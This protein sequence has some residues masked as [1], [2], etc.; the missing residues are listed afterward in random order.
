MRNRASRYPFAAIAFLVG[1]LG[2]AITLILGRGGSGAVVVLLVC[3][4][5]AFF[6]GYRWYQTRETA[7]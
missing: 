7:P 4:F 1:V 6:Y 2:N 3:A 5:A